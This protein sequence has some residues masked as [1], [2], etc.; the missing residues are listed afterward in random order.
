[1]RRSIVPGLSNQLVFP[2]LTHFRREQQLTAANERN[3][4]LSD[5]LSSERKSNNHL[6]KKLDNANSKFEEVSSQNNY[7]VTIS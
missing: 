5:E 7:L 4:F 1:M 3:D 6:R 2:A